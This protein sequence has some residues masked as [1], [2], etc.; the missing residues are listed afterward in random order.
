MRATQLS[1]TFKASLS[2]VSVT[3]PH[4]ACLQDRKFT[5]SNTTFLTSGFPEFPQPHST[6]QKKEKQ[7]RLI[8]KR[9]LFCILQ[10]NLRHF[11]NAALKKQ[12]SIAMQIA[13]TRTKIKY[14]WRNG[15]WNGLDW[16]LMTEGNTKM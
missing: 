9:T 3:H 14:I 7:S 13:L 2:I 12:A 10:R 15:N 4:V 1:L 6:A 8:L 11:V 16:L 5:C